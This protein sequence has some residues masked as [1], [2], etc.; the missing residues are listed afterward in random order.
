MSGGLFVIKNKN[1]HNKDY[2]SD[3]LEKTSEYSGIMFKIKT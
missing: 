3:V 1:L 2:Y